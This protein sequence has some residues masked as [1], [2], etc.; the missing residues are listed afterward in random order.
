MSM[1]RPSRFKSSYQ[2]SKVPSAYSRWCFAKLA[3]AKVFTVLDAKDGFYQV[4]LD[5]ENL[6]LT[7]F[8]S[9]F[10]RYRY[11]PMPQGTPQPNQRISALSEWSTCKSQWYRSNC[12]QHSVL[13]QWRNCERCSKGTWQQFTDLAGLCSQHEFEVKQEKVQAEARP[14]HLH[15]WSRHAYNG[16]WWDLAIRSHLKDSG[17]IP[18][19]WR[20]L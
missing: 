17:Q 6:M 10:G 18:W 11:L 20:P 4:K 13:W 8:W 3:K 15:T 16:L 14:S 2:E 19:K 9:P 1:N 7:I 12:R 5:K